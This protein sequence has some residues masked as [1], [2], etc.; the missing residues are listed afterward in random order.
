MRQA[1]LELTGHSGGGAGHRWDTSEG[2]EWRD[3][4]ENAKTRHRDKNSET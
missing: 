1:K 3:G 2:V 4:E